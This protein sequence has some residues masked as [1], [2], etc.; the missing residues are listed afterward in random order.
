MGGTRRTGGRL[1]NLLGGLLAIVA[2][3]V[4]FVRELQEFPRSAFWPS[5]QGTVITSRLSSSDDD[6]SLDFEYRY[7]VDGVPY[8]SDRVT[9]FQYVVMSSEE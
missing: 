4:V 1:F 5:V 2:L 7:T 3:I 9:F 8:T 6:V